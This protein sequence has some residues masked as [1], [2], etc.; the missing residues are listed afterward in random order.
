MKTLPSYIYV[1]GNDK[2]WEKLKTCLNSC[3]AS[4]KTDNRLG[5]QTEPPYLTS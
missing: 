1:G 5:N 4:D 3:S 2:I